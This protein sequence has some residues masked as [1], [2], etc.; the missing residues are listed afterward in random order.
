MGISSWVF[1]KDGKPAFSKPPSQ[2]GWLINICAVQHVWRMLRKAGFKYFETR[3][4]NQDPLENT[5]GVIRLHVVQTITQL[6]DSL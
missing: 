3:N 4:L 2:T 6:L 1:L 5:F